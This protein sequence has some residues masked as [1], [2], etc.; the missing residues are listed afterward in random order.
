MEE[1]TIIYRQF[2][3]DTKP[4][5]MI[6]KNMSGLKWFALE[7]NYGSSYGDIHKK[8]KFKRTPKLLDIGDGNIR[9]MIEEK[10]EPFNEKIIYYSDPNEQY[11]GGKSNTIYHNLVKTYFGDEYDGTIIDEKH[12]VSGNKYSAK[13]LEGPSEIVI[14]KDFEDLLEEYNEAK[15]K[16]KKTNKKKKKTNKKKKKTNKKKKKNKKKT[17]KKKIN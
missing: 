14:W 8:F 16:K 5:V 2:Y 4:E 12:L 6:P 15:G 1:G 17:N 9:E 3:K 7:E 10:I 11:S 13:D